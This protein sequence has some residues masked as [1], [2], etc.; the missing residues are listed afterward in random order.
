M[1]GR[2]SSLKPVSTSTKWLLPAFLVARTVPSST[3]DSA[4]RKRPGSSSRPRRWPRWLRPACAPHPTG[5]GS[6]WCRWWHRQHVGDGQAAAGGNRMQVHAGRLGA[7]DQLD[8][9]A[10]DFLQ[11]AVVHARA[12]VHVQAGQ[13]Q[14]AGLDGVQRRF[15]SL[16]QM[17]CLLCSPPVLVLLLWP[18]PKPGLMRSQTWWPLERRPAGAACRW[19]RRSRAPGA[20][21]RWPAWPRPSGRR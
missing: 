20:P 19:S 2:I 12:D 4:T 21:P 3:P 18:W 7:L 10:A 11:M 15:S 17:P 13:H 1:L 9:G 14:A 8:H 5:R 16:C 6:G